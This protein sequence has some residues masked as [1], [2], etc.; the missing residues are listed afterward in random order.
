MFTILDPG[1]ISRSSSS[2]SC[3]VTSLFCE[4]ALWSQIPHR[5]LHR[6]FCVSVVCTLACRCPLLTCVRLL[7]CWLLRYA[8]MLLSMFIWIRLFIESQLKAHL[9]LMQTLIRHLV[10]K[11]WPLTL[12]IGRK[13]HMSVLNTFW[14]N[15]KRWTRCP[16]RYCLYSH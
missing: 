4:A 11:V 16:Q 10:V 5:C 8:G 2:S 7:T 12:D 9:S 6:R 13:C 14:D 15:S 1:Q 3:E